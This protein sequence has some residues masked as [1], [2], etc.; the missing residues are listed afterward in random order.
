[1]KYHHIFILLIMLLSS[2]NA[3]ALLIKL[4]FSTS[5]STDMWGNTTNNFDV[6][7]ASGLNESFSTVSNAILTA[8]K[9]DYYSTSYSFIGANQQLDIDFMI[10]DVGTDVSAIDAEHY[11]MQ[12][13]SRVGGPNNGLG[14]ACYYCVANGS[15]LPNT[16]FGSVFSNNIFNWLLPTAGGSWDLNEAINAIAGTL[17]HEIA[18]GLGLAHPSGPESNPGESIYGIM[19]TGAAPSSMPNSERLKNR[20]FS[21]DNMALLA[22]NIGLRTIKV[23]I[24]EPTSFALF[25]SALLLIFRIRMQK[26][27]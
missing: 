3:N 19:A 17:S 13:G 24:P 15:V 7:Q 23:P 26:N 9:E 21:D 16:I 14:V 4:D 2:V 22:R 18:H 20:A 11:T 6:N 12:I 8:V 1:M 10:A 5:G 27:L 25:A